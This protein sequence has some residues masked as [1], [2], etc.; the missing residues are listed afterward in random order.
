[1]HAN[2]RVLVSFRNNFLEICSKIG[3]SMPF[4][5]H[6]NTFLKLVQTKK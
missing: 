5:E 1:M 2:T 3:G 4:K 6:I